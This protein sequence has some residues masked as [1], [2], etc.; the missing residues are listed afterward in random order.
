MGGCGLAPRHLGNGGLLRSAAPLG[1]CHQHLRQ[2]RVATR[3]LERLRQR[4][5]SALEDPH[6]H[7][8]GCCGIPWQSQPLHLQPQLGRR[9]L[10]H[11]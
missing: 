1:L 2:L 7:A 11:L 10:R 4:R 9:R 3:Q 6:L 8:G 5:P